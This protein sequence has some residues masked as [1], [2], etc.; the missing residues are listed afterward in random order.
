MHLQETREMEEQMKLHDQKTSSQNQNAGNPPKATDLVWILSHTKQVQR[1]T[2]DK[3]ENL[4]MRWALDDVKES[5]F[6][7]SEMIMTLQLC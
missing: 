6:I 3:K 5:L 7:L 2:W 4:N 1:D